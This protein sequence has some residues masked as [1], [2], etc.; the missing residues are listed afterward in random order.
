MGSVEELRIWY[1]YDMASTEWVAFMICLHEKYVCDET[2]VWPGLCKI[3]LDII[4]LIYLLMF[5]RTLV[6]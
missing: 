4:P 5:L 1:V 6:K 2:K 3:Y